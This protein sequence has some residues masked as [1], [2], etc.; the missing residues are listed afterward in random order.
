MTDAN[1]IRDSERGISRRDLL[2]SASGGVV[3]S[4]AAAFLSGCG[5]GSDATSS[6]VGS[7]PGTLSLASMPKGFS[8]QVLQRRWQAVR[9]RMKQVGLDCLICPM[10]SENNSDIRYLTDTQAEFAIFP[11]AGDPIA[12]FRSDRWA[13]FEV[14]RAKELGVDLRVGR[15]SGQ[16]SIGVIETLREL[17]MG[18]ARIGVGGLSG[19]LGNAEGAIPYTTF[20][21]IRQAFPRATFESAA[22]LLMRMKLVWHS[23]EEIA[24]FEKVTEVSEA[25][26]QALMEVAR[27]G[28][29]HR[30]AWVHVYHVMLEAT[31]EPPY[32]CSFRAGA[33]GNT[34]LGSPLDE[35]LRAGKIVNQELCATLLGLNVQINHSF[36]LGSPAPADWP[37]AAEYCIDILHSLVDWITPGKS[38]KDLCEFYAQRRQGRPGA[39]PSEAPSGS[40]LVRLSGWGDGPRFGVGRMEGLD[41]LLIEAGMVFTMKPN[42]PIRDTSPAAQFGDAVLVTENGARR[43]GKRKLEVI[44]AGA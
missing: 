39:A 6:A 23:E 31:G 27:P 21:N 33:S 8:R 32:R 28:V 19:V 9:E 38:F 44:T 17:G 13:H 41:D 10:Q 37:A 7:G 36:L 4:M 34:S 1:F 42:V 20:D 40:V 3:A 24:L 43:L 25:G 14:P 12:L 35:I 16:W 26:L 2:Q 5:A 30:D 22:D 18:G 11:L 29:M 15:W